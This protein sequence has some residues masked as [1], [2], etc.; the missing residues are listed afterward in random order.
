LPTITNNGYAQHT[1][2]IKDNAKFIS[3]TLLQTLRARAPLIKFRHIKGQAALQA[4]QIPEPPKVKDTRSRNAELP[5]T[6]TPSHRFKRR[7]IDKNEMDY[8][9]VIHAHSN[10]FTLHFGVLMR[11]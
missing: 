10:R 2:A 5:I 4:T 1:P 6:Y 7:G 11:M 9:Q 8:I 3:T